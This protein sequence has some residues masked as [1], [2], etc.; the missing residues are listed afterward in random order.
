VR[1]QCHEFGDQCC[2]A[3]LVISTLWLGAD[4]AKA[5]GV[6]NVTS[7]NGSRR[8]SGHEWRRTRSLRVGQRQVVCPVQPHTCIRVL[9]FQCQDFAGRDGLPLC[10]VPFAV[11]QETGTP[12]ILAPVHILQERA[13]PSGVGASL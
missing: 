12:I 11:R 6:G 13:I 7:P 3:P 5:G 2:K 10:W 4:R 9:G 1:L 8:E